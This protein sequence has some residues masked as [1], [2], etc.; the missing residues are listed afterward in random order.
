MKK[1]CKE[2][3]Y[4]YW[5]FCKLSREGQSEM[6]AKIIADKHPV[7]IEVNPDGWTQKLKG[8]ATGSLGLKTLY[9]NPYLYF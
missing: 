3:G 9:D 5:K 7:F 2:E 6:D 1:F 4:D 8:L